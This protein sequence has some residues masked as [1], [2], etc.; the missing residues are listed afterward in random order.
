MTTKSDDKTPSPS[1]PNIK[2]LLNIGL[3]KNKQEWLKFWKLIPKFED[4]FAVCFI[5]FWPD[6]SR[7]MKNQN[8]QNPTKQWFKLS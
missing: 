6:W 3:L 5:N 2:R 8:F 4:H 1:D 7:S